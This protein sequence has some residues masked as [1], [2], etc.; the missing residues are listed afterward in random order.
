[1]SRFESSSTHGL[2]RADLEARLSEVQAEADRLGQALAERDLQFTHATATLHGLTE[3]IGERDRRLS[4]AKSTNFEVRRW[5]EE[6]M[7]SEREAIATE[8]ERIRR[9]GEAAQAM[10]EASISEARSQTDATLDEF[11]SELKAER[12]KSEVQ[13][14]QLDAARDAIRSRD[15]R[16][17]AALKDIHARDMQIRALYGSTSWKLMRPFRVLV[18]LMRGELQLAEVRRRVLSRLSRSRLG[19]LL[20]RRP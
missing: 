13:A 16:I 1:M 15:Q 18:M 9:E 10:L 5:A 19:P 7:L 4:A 14:R 17:D 12:Q 11:R 2:E 20:R 3:E 6:E 8:I